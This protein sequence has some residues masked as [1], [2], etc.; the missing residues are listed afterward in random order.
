MQ[1][2]SIVLAEVVGGAWRPGIGDPTLLGWVT[3]VAYFTAAWGCFRA[4]WHEPS[5][6]GR[7]RR[8]P[9]PFWLVLWALMVALGINKQL[10][11]QSLITVVGRGMFRQHGLY[12]RRRAFQFAFILAVAAI[13]AGLLAAFLM[14]SRRSLRRRWPALVGMMFLL[15]FVIIRAASFHHVDALLAARLGGLK[16]NWIFE[17]GGIIVLGVG[18]YRVAATQPTAT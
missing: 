4:A 18:A 7:R 16:W 17:L 12:E 9:T 3:V 8:S 10:D 14:A 1:I 13:C 5:S 15:G 6:D 2:Q 11:L